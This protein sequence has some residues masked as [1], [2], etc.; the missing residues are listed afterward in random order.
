ELVDQM[1]GRHADQPRQLRWAVGAQHRTRGFSITEIGK[2]PRDAGDALVE[3]VERQSVGLLQHFGSL[4][5]IALRLVAEPPAVTVDLE[6]TLADDGEGDENAVRRR[7][8]AVPLVSGQAA[9]LR[10]ELLAPENGVA[11]V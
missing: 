3:N 11:L 1:R 2:L 4:L 6:S 8:R 10:A 5:R 7:H 9:Q